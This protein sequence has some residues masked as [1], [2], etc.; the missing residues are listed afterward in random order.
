MRFVLFI[1]CF[2]ELLLFTWLRNFVGP[3]ISPVLLLLCSLGIGFC[4]LK[5]DASTNYLVPQN[6]NNYFGAKKRRITAGLGIVAFLG[7][8][9]VMFD[10]L[11]NIWKIAPISMNVIQQSDVIPQ[12]MFLVARYKAGVF[13]YQVITGWGYDLF[14]TYLPLQWFPY[15]FADWLHKDYRWV[16]AIVLWLACAYFFVKNFSVH[17]T[18]INLLL[19]IF[20]PLMPLLV[21]YAVV[22]ND[23]YTYIFTVEELI[24]GYYLFAATSISNKNVLALSFGIG[25]CLLSR[26]SIVFWVPLCMLGYYWAG[27]RKEVLT[28]SVVL[29]F[30]FIAFYWFPFLRIDKGVFFKGYEYHRIAA[31]RDW[32]RGSYMHNG[33]GFSAYA[34][35]FVPGN[36]ERK[37]F[38]YQFVHLLACVATVIALGAFY[39]KRMQC[40]SLSTFLLFAFKVYLTVFYMFIQTQYSY[41]YITPLIISSALLVG[42]FRKD[43]ARSVLSSLGV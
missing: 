13:P 23:G 11:R 9:W 26:Y 14:P 24:A 16:P 32:V 39:R 40:Y 34:Y 22:Q 3:Y 4:F 41:L 43:R 21:W 37:L 36:I 35:D 28:M 42:A 2:F 31:F 17:A 12:I 29:A 18:G 27:K 30:M 10:L 7:M 6:A 15:F 25:L 38:V 33:L 8:S 5:I 19:K 1:L 20:L